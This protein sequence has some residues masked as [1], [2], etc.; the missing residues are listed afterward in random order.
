MLQHQVLIIKG[1]FGG[2]G[3]DALTFTFI[4]TSKFGKINKTRDCN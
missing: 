1:S 4:T 3:G 2:A